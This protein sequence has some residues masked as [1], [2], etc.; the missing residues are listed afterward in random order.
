EGLQHA[1]D[2]NIYLLNK[3]LGTNE[4]YESPKFKSDAALIESASKLITDNNLSSKMI[5]VAPVSRWES[6]NWP[7]DFYA[8][9]LNKVYERD[10]ECSFWFVGTDDD[11]STGEAIAELCDFPI[12]NLMGKTDL[13]LLFNL[14]STSKALLSNDSGPM[15]MAA[16]VETPVV[17]MFGPTSAEK[18]GPYG[19]QHT[20]LQSQVEC[21]PCYN[22][23]CPLEKQICLDDFS[24]D[25]VAEI[26]L[27]LTQ[28]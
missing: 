22:R 27:K 23:L 28:S 25:K 20:V 16:A 10:P 3:A 7:I 9:A 24:P 17:A 12:A 14:L 13:T 15:H 4:P 6:K 8:A 2:K 5:A 21:S 19:I 11:Y 1:V 26:L 18:T